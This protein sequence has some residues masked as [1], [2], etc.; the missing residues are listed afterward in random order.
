MQHRAKNTKKIHLK[1]LRNL[2]IS[3]ELLCKF[4]YF[5]SPVGWHPRRPLHCDHL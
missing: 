1:I 3:E 2:Q 4:R 5:V